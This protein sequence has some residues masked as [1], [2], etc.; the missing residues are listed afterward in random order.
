MNSEDDHR[1][2]FTKIANPNTASPTLRVIK[3]K[4]SLI[5]LVKFA[6]KLIIKI[7]L[8][9]SIS[10]IKIKEIKWFLLLI[11]INTKIN[12]QKKIIELAEN[13][14]I[15]IFKIIPINTKIRIKILFFIC[16]KRF[17]WPWKRRRY[18]HYSD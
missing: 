1:I 7:L 6:K 11:K 8:I 3:I 5:E 15:L 10:K 2:N 12:I 17:Y 13:S 14:W 4:T 16:K 9:D 18:F